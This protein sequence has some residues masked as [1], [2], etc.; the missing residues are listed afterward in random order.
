M[1][2]YRVLFKDGKEMT[3]NADFYGLASDNHF[4]QFLRGKD[5]IAISIPKNDIRLIEDI[6][7][8]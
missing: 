8:D 6:S 7:S 4:I 3:I 2:T 5:T 1:K